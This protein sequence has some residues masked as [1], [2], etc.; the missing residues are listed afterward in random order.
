MEKLMKVMEEVRYDEFSC[1]SILKIKYNGKEYNEKAK[2]VIDAM[3][4]KYG[5]PTGYPK[6]NKSFFD[7]L[8]KLD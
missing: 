7:P 6:T 5:W 3:T 1:Q 2:V 4:W 8:F